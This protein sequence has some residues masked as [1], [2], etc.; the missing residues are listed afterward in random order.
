MC[1]MWIGHHE[2]HAKIILLSTRT[3]D[4]DFEMLSEL[5]IDD[6]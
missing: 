3:Q 1:L 6:K 2:N 4:F 5:L